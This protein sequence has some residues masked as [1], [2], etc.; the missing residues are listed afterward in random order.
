MKTEN[1]IDFKEALKYSLSPVPLRL[2][3]ADGAKS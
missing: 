1:K 2:C 3:Y